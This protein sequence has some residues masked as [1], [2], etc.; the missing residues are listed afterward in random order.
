MAGCR[1]AAVVEVV[2]V[3]A[4][5]R[6]IERACRRGEVLRVVC[7]ARVVAPAER[8]VREGPVRVRIRL[9]SDAIGDRSWRA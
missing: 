4:R 7:V 5:D 9:V 2:A 3:R 8:P 6:L 1:A